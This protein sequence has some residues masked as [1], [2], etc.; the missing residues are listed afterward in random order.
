MNGSNDFFTS[1]A[2][3]TFG[4]ITFA[5]TVIV[6]TF[7]SLTNREPKFIAFLVSLT[8]CFAIAWST[9]KQPLDY[10]IALLNGCLVYCTSMGLNSQVNISTTTPSKPPT[11]GEKRD[12]FLKLINHFFRPW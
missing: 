1:Q 6:N 12:K 10:L 9:I 8:L 7:R 4:G 2:L 11:R 5:I 3:V